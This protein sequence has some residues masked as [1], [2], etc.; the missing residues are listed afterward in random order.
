MPAGAEEVGPTCG[1]SYLG[2]QG[3]A[4]VHHNLVHLAPS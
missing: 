3:Q 1:W 4:G 2:K